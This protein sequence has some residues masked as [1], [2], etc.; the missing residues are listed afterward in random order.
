M[1]YYLVSLYTS[2][3]DTPKISI[4]EAPPGWCSR[5]PR[6]VH[7]SKGLDDVF[8]AS[9]AVQVESPPLFFFYDGLLCDFRDAGLLGSAC[10]GPAQESEASR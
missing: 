2:N 10:L 4:V 1:D 6:D 8:K 9:S 5:P 3:S 7:T